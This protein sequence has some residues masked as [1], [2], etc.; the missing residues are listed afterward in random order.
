MLSSNYERSLSTV[1][2]VNRTDESSVC[3]MRKTEWFKSNE[4]FQDYPKINEIVNLT[5]KTSRVSRPAE[6]IVFYNQDFTSEYVHTK[7]KH[8]S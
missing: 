2:Y 6:D 8:S 1:T 5:K 7:I 3:S 4:G